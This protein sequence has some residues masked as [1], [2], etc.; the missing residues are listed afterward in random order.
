MPKPIET[1]DEDDVLALPRGEN[2]TFERKGSRLLDLTIPGVTQDDV[3]NELGKQLSAF[4]NTGGGRIY[5]GVADDGTVD[6]GGITRLIRGRQTAKD[7]LETVAPAVVEY[8][9]V[10]VNVYEVLPKPAGSVIAPD[11]S[12]YIVDIPD[13]ERAPHQSKRDSKYYVRL[14]GRSQPA[15]HKLIE[16]I[17]NRRR[18]PVWELTSARLQVLHL[19]INE[20]VV[21]FDPVLEISGEASVR[22]YLNLKNVSSTIMAMH[23]S[24]RIDYFPGSS[25]WTNYDNLTV[26]RRGEPPYFWEF[27]API[28]P[29]MEIALW[30]DAKVSCVYGNV[31]A[32]APRGGPWSFP[33]S[34]ADAV[35]LPWMIFAD[36]APV[37]TGI[38]RF[39]DLRFEQAA[40]T[41][42]AA[43]Q[44][45]N[46]IGITYP[47]ILMPI[48]AI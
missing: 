43:H 48:R 26:T 15:S 18:H 42:L 28:Y 1:W 33:G 13:S 34:A 7:W 22:L 44:D 4:A 32:A 30:M 6:S 17:R 19:P 31:T 9:I 40:A 16:D 27:S 29:G 14:G 21:G 10:G 39:D 37:R 20:R 11:K 12:L 3:L 47:D 36:N 45:R 8:E 24:L 41:Y 46:R 23:A 25:F 5:Y 38:L 2:D 35:G